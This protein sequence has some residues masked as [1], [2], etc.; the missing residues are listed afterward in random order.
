MY[1]FKQKKIA[2]FYRNFWK[3]GPRNQA[4]YP[5]T[6]TKNAREILEGLVNIDPNA[7][8]ES[9]EK[10]DS[11]INTTRLNEAVSDTCGGFL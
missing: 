3:N 1:C 4:F 10:A 9:K 6:I 2:T 8:R 7:L 11:D 5:A